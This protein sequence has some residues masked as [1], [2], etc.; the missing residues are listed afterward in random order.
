[1]GAT[2]T[3]TGSWQGKLKGGYQTATK[4]AGLADPPAGYIY[5]RKLNIADRWRWGKGLTS[6]ASSA[7]DL[8]YGDD[9]T[10]TNGDDS[11]QSAG[12]PQYIITNNEIIPSPPGSGI[13]VETHVAEL[14]TAWELFEIPTTVSPPA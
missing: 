11:T 14:Y 2:F 3:T 13:W 8:V 6:W 4:V 12:E 1:M 5:R 10:I 7:G 9:L